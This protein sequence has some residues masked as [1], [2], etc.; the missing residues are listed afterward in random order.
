[1][2][3]Q[4]ENEL[5]TRVG[6]GSPAGQ[7][8]R[9]YWH[10]VAAAG[11][12]TGA[13]PKKRVRILGEDL[14]LYRDRSG[15]YGLVGE[16]C[17]HRGASLYYGFVEEDGIRCAYH[18]WKYDACGKCLEQ[19]FENPEA[20]FKE[21]IR[22]PAYPVAK[23]SGLLFA[24][25]GPPDKKPTLPKWD[26]LVREDG[27]KKIDICEVLRCNWL[28]A[29]E[30]SVDPT[31]TYYLHSHNL[32][33]KGAK[34]YVPFHYQPLSKIEFDLVIQPTWAG[35]QKQRVFAGA[36]TPVEAPHPLIFPNILFVPVRLGYA[37]HFRT[38]IDDFNT[39]VYQFRFSPAK[40]GKAVDP[41]EDPPIEYV[42]TKNAE[43]DF[44][45]DNFTSQDHMAW[46]TQG[47]V[48]NRAKEHLGESDRGIIMFRKLLQDQIQAVQNSQDPIG[49]NMDPEKDQVIQLIHEGYS[50]FSFA[51]ERAA[52]ERQV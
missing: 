23:L 37:L 39:Q 40:D 46:E 18:G 50:A 43:G 21:R 45:M 8:L 20:S 26:I 14:V 4:E 29:M 3:T 31:H 25:M 13:K 2:L 15:A 32:K 38:P 1:M 51:A 22:H 47:S 27:M 41:A 28:Q 16:H 35:I 9:R 33:L 44:H 11:E 6:P 52:Q 48:A 36:D 17:S 34:D 49:T 19:P 24:Y 7:L 42:G 12:L 5:L 10:V 30:N